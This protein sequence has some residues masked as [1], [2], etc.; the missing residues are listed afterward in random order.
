MEPF[1]CIAGLM[2]KR[3]LYAVK[4]IELKRRIGIMP[5]DCAAAAT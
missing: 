4:V 1:I 3:I 2:V 5:S